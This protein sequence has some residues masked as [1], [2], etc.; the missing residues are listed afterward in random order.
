MKTVKQE[1]SVTIII[2][3]ENEKRQ[4]SLYEWLSS[5]FED[6][7]NKTFYG[8][9]ILA[10]DIYCEDNVIKIDMQVTSHGEYYEAFHGTY[11]DPPE[12]AYIEGLIEENDFLSWINGIIPDRFE[13]TVW[14]SEDSEIPT[15]EDLIENMY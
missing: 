4:L 7:E 1:C 9:T 2:E 13:Y 15:E 10:F 14:L 6:T 3:C 8:E 12:P 11:F 5:Y